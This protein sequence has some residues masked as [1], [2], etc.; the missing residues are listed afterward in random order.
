MTKPRK[1]ARSTKL[2]ARRAVEA[3]LQKLVH[4]QFAVPAG[5]VRA[6]RTKLQERCR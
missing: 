1:S 3:E 5:A 2:A 4:S 6:T